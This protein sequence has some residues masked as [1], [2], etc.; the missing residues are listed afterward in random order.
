M[1][2][3]VRM[4]FGKHRG[5]PLCEIPESYLYWVLDNCEN[6]SPT[7]KKQIEAYLPGD[8]GEPQGT[9]IVDLV[10]AWYRKLA[11]EF[12]PDHKAGSHEGM[13][14]VNRARDLL[15]E[16]SGVQL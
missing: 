7:L 14:A 3:T 13:K 2:D 9:A 12:N 6:A 10:P 8:E 16:M 11:L 15:L 4:P 1:N 5:R